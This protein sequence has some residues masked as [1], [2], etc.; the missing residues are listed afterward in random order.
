[1]STK[2]YG[3][4]VLI[5]GAAGALDAID[6]AA[7]AD[8]DSAFVVTLNQVYRYSLDAD[9][10]A[11]ESSPDVIS[12]DTNAG[13][14]RWILVAK[15]DQGTAIADAPSFAGATLTEPLALT[16]T[17]RVITHLRIGAASFYKG[18][19]PPELDVLGMFPI[20]RFN[21]D[22]DEQAY[23]EDIIPF[24]LTA[25]TVVT[26]SVHWTYQGGADAGK[27]VWGVEYINVATG[28]AV[29]GGTST[30]TGTS[31]GNHTSGQKVN[32]ALNTGIV[33][34]VAEDS[35]GIRIYRDADDGV[36]DTL[37]V[38]AD[39]ISLHLHFIIDKLGQPT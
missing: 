27:V 33:G 5:G 37:A 18:G 6:G 9:S 1:M 28:E 7:L 31:A 39:L 2:C 35:L 16:G 36:N 29:V 21:P 20:L 34:A 22:A 15:S 32:T 12:P 23:Y 30:I 3:A 17:G 10:A 11:G 13:T 14:K 25:G 8:L 26:A 19:N 38:D 4:T 24:K